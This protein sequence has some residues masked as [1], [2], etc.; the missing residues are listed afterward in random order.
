MPYFQLMYV[1]QL[2][3]TFIFGFV[4]VIPSMAQQTALPIHS[5]GVFAER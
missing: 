4:V 2:L 5:L 1:K 3:C